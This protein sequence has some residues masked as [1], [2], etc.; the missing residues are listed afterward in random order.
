MI[1]FESGESGIGLLVA[2]MPCSKPSEIAIVANE[3]IV[4][5]N[6]LHLMAQSLCYGLVESGIVYQDTVGILTVHGVEHIIAQ[7]AIVYAGVS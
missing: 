6:D 3:T 5:Y 2:A 7:L 1:Y 4:T